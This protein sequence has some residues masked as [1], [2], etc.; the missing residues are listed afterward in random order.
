[1]LHLQFLSSG[2]L[3]C[4]GR[5]KNRVQTS[6]VFIE[7]IV[8][9][10][11]CPV[12]ASSH[13]TQCTADRQAEAGS[14]GDWCTANKH[15]GSASHG[16]WC[17]ADKHSGSASHGNQPSKSAGSAG[18]GSSGNWC[19]VNRTFASAA[20]SSRKEVSLTTKSRPPG[21]GSYENQCT[22]DSARST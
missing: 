14:H 11:S 5:H 13:G 9:I 6:P 21:T 7:A 20:S 3:Q 2:C 12:G 22:T 4:H 1:M 16:D 19:T 15:S 18:V 8:C 17:T 10:N